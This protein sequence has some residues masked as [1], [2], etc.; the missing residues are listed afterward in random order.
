MIDDKKNFL[1]GSRTAVLLY[2][3]IADLPVYDIHTH[4]NLNAI[5]RNEPAADPWT[6]LCQGDHYVSSI[7][8]SLGGMPRAEWYD[9]R[10]TPE[11]KWKAYAEV[12]PL[13]IGNQVHDWMR[14]TLDELGVSIPFNAGNAKKIWDQLV[15]TFQDSRWS[16][17]N[18]FKNSKIR[19]MGTTDNPVDSLDAIKRSVEYFPGGFWIPAW[20]PDPFLILNP[21]PLAGKTWMDWIRELEKTGNVD[22][23][24]R[25]TE[26]CATLKSRHDFFAEMGCRISDYGIRIPYGHDVMEKRSR[27][28]FNKA[29]RGQ[30]ILPSEASDFQAFMLRFSWDMDF[31]KGWVS[32]V[33]YGAVRNMR[34]VAKQFGGVDSGCDTTGGY[35]EVATLL[36][37][38]LNHFDHSPEKTQ[39]IFLYTLDKSDW[40]RIAGLSRIFP[41]VYSGMSWWYF[42][43][44]SGM[45]EFL[46]T[47]PDI[48]AGFA[49]IGPFVT[50][51]R[52]IFSLKPRTDLFRRCLAGV[53]A[54]MVDMRKSD[55]SETAALA[56]FLCSDFPRQ[57]V[58]GKSETNPR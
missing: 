46:S 51:A 41:R 22:L 19:L 31:E 17:V 35:P 16:P 54:T 25:W 49:K 39:R 6:A 37:P 12:F 38:L 42:D 26:F 27:T 30:A 4:V 43:S 57:C 18:L 36:R 47:V 20:R 44:V 53:L 10:T 1:L 9:S 23:S 52:N 7:I 21:D 8:E 32:Q 2:E 56:R 48:G 24:G 34:D 15:E 40:P 14:M 29:C 28:I 11:M 33:H 58:T 5:L 13:L 3:S 45:I 50:D 55:F